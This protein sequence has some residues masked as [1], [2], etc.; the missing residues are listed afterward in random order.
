MSF[1]KALAER[2]LE[3]AEK[4]S[5]AQRGESRKQLKGF[6]RASSMGL[7]ARLQAYDFLGFHT[8]HQ[9]SNEK[10]LSLEDGHVHEADVIGR[11]LSLKGVDEVSQNQNIRKAFKLKNGDVLK[12][13]GTPDLEIVDNGK[14]IIVEV[15]A[16][17]DS[18]FQ[19]VRRENVCPEKYAMQCKVYL[20]LR[21]KKHG[22][23][24]IK[25][26]N[27]S[28]VIAFDI[29]LTKEDRKAILKR[30]MWIQ[31]FVRN[32]K[33]PPREYP[34]G[35]QECFYCN[36]NRRCRPANKFKGYIHKKTGAQK[37]VTVDLSDE[38]SKSRFIVAAKGFES[39]KRK[40]DALT[41]L[42]TE[43]KDRLERLLRKY[44]ADGIE[45]DGYS[46]KRISPEQKEIPDPEYV[47]KLLSK[48]NLPMVLRSSNPYIRVDL[49]KG[50]KR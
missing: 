44:K 5:D 6:W 26:R 11:I 37:N 29:T 45:A 27:N 39:A 40:I 18:T 36:H 16:L 35:S 9:E 42:M 12:I 28:N 43:A 4:Y 17:Q 23:V 47:K 19:E 1:A 30:Q 50:S 13:A 38:D 21:G 15:K 2:V 25:N 31:S 20:V 24:Y 49:P 10:R 8:E 14:Y 48:T 34:V 33:L 46:V 41:T 22:I 32:K 7:C 3:S